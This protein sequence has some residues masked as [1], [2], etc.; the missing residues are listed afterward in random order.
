MS[1][2]IDLQLESAERLSSWDFFSAQ[3]I[4]P[5]H[6]AELKTIVTA[7]QTALQQLGIGVIIFPAT[8]GNPRRQKSPLVIDDL[9]LVAAVEEN[10]VNNRGP[11]GTQQ[12]ADLVAEAI[13]W[14]LGTGWKP[15]CEAQELIFD[16]IIIGTET[17]GLLSYEVHFWT[18][19]RISKAPE[20]KI[21]V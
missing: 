6:A 9:K 4:I 7:H 17:N 19:V 15:K 11:Q 10:I 1:V 14:R 3:P 5:V 16:Q 13:A 12:P 18:S 20:R 8:G 21:I 2:V